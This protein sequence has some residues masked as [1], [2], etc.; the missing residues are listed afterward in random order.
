MVAFSTTGTINSTYQSNIMAFFACL[1]TKRGGET[2]VP[3]QAGNGQEW[4]VVAQ[5]RAR[6]GGGGGEK[7]KAGRQ[8][9]YEKK[10]GNRRAP[11]LQN[12]TCQIVGTWQLA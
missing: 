3:L 5:W 7:T 1:K 8:Q 10:P 6:E 4:R 12:R 11:C 9:Q 2:V